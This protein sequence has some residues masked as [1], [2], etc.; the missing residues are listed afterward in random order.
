[1]I[2]EHVHRKSAVLTP[3]DL[4]CLK[5][6]CSVNISSGCA[7]ECVYCYSR[8]YS[9]A[10]PE[11]TVRFYANALEKMKAEWPRKRKKPERVYFC[12]SS[13]LFQPVPEILAAAYEML[14][15]ILEQ[16][17][18]VAITTKGRIPERHLTLLSEDADRVHVQVG[19]TTHR[20]DA[21]ALLEPHAAPVSARIAQAK[22]LREAGVAVKLRVAPILPGVTDDDETLCALCE[23]AA[24][25]G[26]MEVVI[27]TLHLRPAIRRSLE[28]KLPPEMLHRLFA[29]YEN[30]EP[31][32][33]SGRYSQTPLPAGERMA[34]FKRAKRIAEQHGLRAYVCGCMN[35]DISKERCFLAGEDAGEELPAAREAT[36]MTLFNE[37]G[38]EV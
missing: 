35:P 18:R 8:S 30:A 19:L 10:P 25:C 26:I 34:L 15:F 36:Q 21:C 22:R 37:S 20:D 24:Q 13:D 23:I 2:I 17:A 16:G 29:R 27:N 12:P 3:S 33:V 1:M 7:H 38:E 32:R 4:P 31:L 11:G 28:R 9:Q 14:A 5:G 6:V